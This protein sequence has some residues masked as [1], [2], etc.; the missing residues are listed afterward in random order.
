VLFDE[1]DARDGA[2]KAVAAVAKL[3]R[4]NSEIAYEAVVADFGAD[5]AEHLVR[6]VDIVLDGADNFEVRYV[7]N[8]VCVK[9]GKPWV[10][11]AAV[12][13]YGLL[14]PVVP[15]QTPCLRC[16]FPDPPP[17]GTV[18]TCDTAGVLG[19]MPGVVANLAA[20]EG[21]K[22]LA[23]ATE[24]LRRGLL[25]IDGWYNTIQETP[26]VAPV[27]D[28]P[29]C[30]QRNFEFLERDGAA[31]AATLCGRDAV[32]VRAT[33]PGDVDLPALAERLAAIGQVRQNAHLVRFVAPPHELTIFRDGRAIVKGT[34]DPAVARSLYARY[35]GT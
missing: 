23:G 33:R 5:N 6:D 11:A 19:P 13:S 8:D 22:L 9:L 34:A 31:P 20:L 32:Q 21:I 29:A 30:Q 7:V 27:A 17:A 3:Q 2:P 18:D 14:M 28:C 26:V 25:W 10:Y 15:G 12:S 16:V 24:Q 35:V 1:D 4:I